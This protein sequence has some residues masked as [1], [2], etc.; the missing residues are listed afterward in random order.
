[1]AVP[2]RKMSRSHTRTRRARWKAT[3]PDL[4]PVTPEGRR[5]PG[6]G[7]AGPGLPAGPAAAAL[8]RA[9]LTRGAPERAPAT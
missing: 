4:V 6:A 9:S 1:M 8:L 5:H 2:K 7:V 3:A